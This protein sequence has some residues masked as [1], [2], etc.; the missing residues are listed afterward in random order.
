M[1]F[2][3]EIT[4]QDRRIWEEELADFV[5]QKIYDAHSHIYRWAFHTD[6]KKETGPYVKF[7]GDDY[8]EATYD[9]LDSIDAQLMPGREVH[10]LSFPFPYANG[11]DFEASNEFIANEVAGHDPSRALMLVNPSMTEADL[12]DSVQKGG[13]L[14][15]K[16]YRFFSTTGDAVHCRI[17]DFLPEH[18]IAVADRHGLIIMMH[19]SRPEGISDPVNLED[20]EN[21]TTKYPNAKWVLAHCA[22]A[23]SAWPIERAGDRLR[24]MP[25]T[26]FDTS[27]VC[28]SDAM[29]ALIQCVGIERVMYGSDDVPVGVLRGKYVTFGHAWAYLSETNHNMSLVHCDGRMTFT[30]YE[31]LRAMKRAAQRH[32]LG[33]PEIAALFHDNALRLI[34]S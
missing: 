14:G 22:R 33:K 9:F 8:R 31:Q 25:N 3:L 24:D 19:L 20:L 32:G 21:L 28:E 4:D 23:Y 18:Q 26:W 11:C 15:L 30:R 16:P 13:F 1:P 2:K 34:Q 10:R 6:P 27:S 5:P 12:E 7:V 29:D 17:T